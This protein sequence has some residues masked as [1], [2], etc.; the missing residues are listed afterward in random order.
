MRGIGKFFI[1]HWLI[2]PILLAVVNGL[3]YGVKE[4]APSLYSNDIHLIA[5]AT[6]IFIGMSFFAVIFC[7]LYHKIFPPSEKE[8]ITFQ[9]FNRGS[10]RKER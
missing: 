5:I 9:K 8:K 4:L 3:D 6:S 2:F 1:D 10:K 7:W